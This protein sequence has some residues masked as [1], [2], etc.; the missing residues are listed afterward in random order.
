MVDAGHDLV[1]YGARARVEK[2]LVVLM[3]K[4]QPHVGEAGRPPRQA[5]PPIRLVNV[6]EPRIVI[7]LMLDA[8]FEIDEEDRIDIPVDPRVD[9]HTVAAALKSALIKFQII[10]AG[11]RANFCVYGPPRREG[12]AKIDVAVEFIIV[13]VGGFYGSLGP[14]QRVVAYPVDAHTE[15]E[16]VVFGV[17]NE[18]HATGGIEFIGCRSIAL[19]PGRVGARVDQPLDLALGAELQVVMNCTCKARLYRALPRILR[20]VSGV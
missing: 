12:M 8:G 16:Q 9:A 14:L 1:A 3:R 4:V 18:R 20:R 15:A 19:K 13:A 11:V 7:G 5:N 17:S 2:R 6:A 10:V